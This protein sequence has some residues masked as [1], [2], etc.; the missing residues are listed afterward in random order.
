MLNSNALA[1]DLWQKL[2]LSCDSVKVLV[3][4]D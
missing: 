4:V 1:K 2:I 3:K